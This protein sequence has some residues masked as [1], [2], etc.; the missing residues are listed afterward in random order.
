MSFAEYSGAGKSVKKNCKTLLQLLLK[1]G[2]SPAFSGTL[3][4]KRLSFVVVSPNKGFLS[5]DFG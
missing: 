3:S 4:W 1:T 5:G 2:F